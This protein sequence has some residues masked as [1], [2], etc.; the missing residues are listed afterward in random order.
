MSQL[1]RVA[2]VTFATSFGDKPFKNFEREIERL[3][4]SVLSFGLDFY[5]YTLTELKDAIKDSP[6][7][8][9]TKFRKGVG[10]WFWKPFVILH[11]LENSRYDYVLYLDVDCILLRDPASV[12]ESLPNEVELAGFRMDAQIGDWTV[13]RIIENFQA[14]ELRDASMWTA[15]I[16]FVKNTEL[17]KSRLLKWLEAM[18]KPWNLFELPFEPGGIR[19]R[20]DQSLFSILIA[21]DEIQVYDL[22]EGFYSQGIEATSPSVENAWVAT[23]VNLEEPLPNVELSF[24]QVLYRAILHRVS[25]FSKGTFWIVFPFIFLWKKAAGRFY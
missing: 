7:Q 8:G 22:G 14:G 5:V 17:A 3:R 18:S 20:H 12:L 25:G 1:P 16:L 19:H 15:G 4:G 11:Y 6:F 2:V 24:T 23:G 9:Y 13:D 21:K 10:G